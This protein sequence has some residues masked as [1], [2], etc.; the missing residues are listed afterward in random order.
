M[1]AWKKL[2]SDVRET[3]HRNFTEAALAERQDFVT[4]TQSE[5]DNL[6]AKGLTFNA[7]DNKLF[8]EALTKSGFYVDMKKTMGDDGWASLEKY[9]GALS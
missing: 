3:V 4:M 1:A 9:V 8:R 6:T 5:Q 7:P 2:P